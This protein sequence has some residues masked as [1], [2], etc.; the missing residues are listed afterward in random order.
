MH[1]VDH[2]G[3]TAEELLSRLVYELLDAHADTWDQY[4]RERYF[5]GTPFRRAVEEGLLDPARSLLAGMRGP[6]YAAADVTQPVEMGFE[7][8]PGEGE[9]AEHTIIAVG[10]NQANT[11][12]F[13]MFVR[14]PAAPGAEDRWRDLISR[15]SLAEFRAAQ[16]VVTL[17]LG[18]LQ[19]GSVSFSPPLPSAVADPIGRLG[20]GTYD[21]VFLR[22]AE[23]F[24]DDAYVL[25]QQGAAGVDMGRNIF[26]SD[27]P[28]AMIAAVHAVVHKNMKPAD[29]YETYKAL[30]NKG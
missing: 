15:Y 18:V 12:Y 6:L 10:A 28:K 1:H 14:M 4:Y 7:V 30:K 5:H 16:A 11:L 23:K 26:Q 2:T 3:I 13:E 24:W 21:K 29:A 27:A 17:P 25:R 20:M 19:A 9:C 8:I 22:F